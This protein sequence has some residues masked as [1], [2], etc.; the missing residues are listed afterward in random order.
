MLQDLLDLLKEPE[1]IVD[2]D[3]YVEFD[4]ITDDIFETE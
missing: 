3:E 4:N 1:V 2:E